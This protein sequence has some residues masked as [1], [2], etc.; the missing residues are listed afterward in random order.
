MRDLQVRRQMVT[1]VY[2]GILQDCQNYLK[3]RE[4][5]IITTAGTAGAARRIFLFAPLMHQ[6]LMN[7]KYLGVIDKHQ[8]EIQV[9]HLINVLLAV[10]EFQTCSPTN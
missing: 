1:L 6:L 9:C 7:V 10:V 3:I 5:G 4:I 8:F 2:R